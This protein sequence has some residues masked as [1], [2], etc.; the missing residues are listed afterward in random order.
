VVGA[1]TSVALFHGG[2]WAVGERGMAEHSR[3]SFPLMMR[4]TGSTVREVP[5]PRTTYGGALNAVAATSAANAWAVGN[6]ATTGGGSGPA[7]IVHWNGRRWARVQL[8]ATVA[9]DVAEVS[10]VAATSSTNA[11]IVSLWRI[12]HWNGRRWNVASPAIGLRYA[13]SSVAATS[14][15]DVWAVGNGLSRNVAVLLHWN[16]LRWACALS[17]QIHPPK[18]PDLSLVAVS[19]SSAGNAWAVGSYF[20]SAH[21]ALALHWNGRTW[22]QVLTPQPGQENWLQ[23]V[24]VIPHSGGAWAVGSTDSGTLMLHWNGTAWQ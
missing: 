19:A 2:A 16:G 9:R 10:G 8:P 23:G 18:F 21:R 24:S 14:P 11:W 1:L 12:L 20:D 3:V 6:E 7:L 15:K 5:I 22:K 17:A 4:V 13:L